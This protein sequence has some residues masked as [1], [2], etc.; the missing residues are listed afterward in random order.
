MDRF[1]NNIQ[2]WVEVDNKLK[3]LN[4]EIRAYRNQKN[5]LADQIHSVVETN[6]LNKAVI[7]ISD[8]SLKFN[9]VKNTSPLTLKFISKCLSECISNVDTVDNLLKYIKNQ[10]E[11]KYIPQIK[12][13]YK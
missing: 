10:R 4:E 9:T 5:E 7:E 2:K 8:G 13:N 6:N 3:K 12:R 11:S 1:Q